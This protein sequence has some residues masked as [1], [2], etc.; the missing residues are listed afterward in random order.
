MATQIRP[1][2]R[3]DIP[4]LIEIRNGVRENPLTDPGAVTEADAERFI[5]AGMLWVWQEA[6][7]L[8]TGFSAADAQDGSIWALF[9]APGHD[10]KGI[11]RALL[12][13]ACD[14]LRATGHR[15]AWLTAEPGTPAERHYRAAGWTASGTGAEGELIF[16]KAL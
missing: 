2:T 16:R 9:V 14:G 10:G 5:E 12:A 6:D 13:K 8:V 1:A 4:R 11:G 7:G 3:E 15:E